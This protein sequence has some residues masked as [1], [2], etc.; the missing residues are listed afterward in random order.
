[1]KSRYLPLFAALAW[2]GWTAAATQSQPPAGKEPAPAKA[3][4]QKKEYVGSEACA[5]CHDEIHTNFKKNAHILLETA[6]GRGWE[7]KACESCHG[8]GSVHAESTSA[9]DI[10]T[11]KNMSP[12]A[13]DQMRLACHRNQETQVGRIQSGH[14]RNSVP[15]TSCHNVHKTGEESSARQF[16]RPAGVNRNCQGCHMDV[17]ASFQKPH[18]HPLPEGAMSCTEL[19]QP[20]RQLPEP[21]HAAGQ[22][23]AAWL[24]PVPFGQARAVRLRA[25]AR[26]QRAL[27]HLPRARTVRPTRA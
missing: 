5:G 19:P 12:A 20:A 7:G 24:L 16:R 8:P 13:I 26:A 6:K 23:A 21:E 1:M 11:P 10:L 4:Q 17:W 9:E 27:H 14:A 22:R 25:R 2:A 3:V 18:R 15:C